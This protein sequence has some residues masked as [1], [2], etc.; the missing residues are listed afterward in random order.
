[1][2]DTDQEQRSEWDRDEGKEK[3]KKGSDSG[4]PN[5]THWHRGKLVLRTWSGARVDLLLSVRHLRQGNS[6]QGT[7]WPREMAELSGP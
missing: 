2:C 6:E 7:K 1:M 4:I 5:V 3:R